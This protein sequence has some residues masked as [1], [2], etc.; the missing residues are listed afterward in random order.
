MYVTIIF[1]QEVMGLRGSCENTGAG[2]RGRNEVEFS[3]I[4]FS[5]FKEKYD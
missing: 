1:I 2:V 4:K 5:N 3:C